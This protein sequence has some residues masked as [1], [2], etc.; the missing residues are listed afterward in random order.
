MST[1]EREGGRRPGE[2]E[3]EKPASAERV[4][5]PGHQR[6]A[7]ALEVALAPTRGGAAAPATVDDVATAAIDGKDRGAAADSDRCRAAE[8]HVL[9]SLACP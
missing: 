4:R 8:A 1:G 7:G 9:A 3:P 5:H 2:G 6:P